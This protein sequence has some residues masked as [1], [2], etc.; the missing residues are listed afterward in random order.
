M[1]P[2]S[3]LICVFICVCLFVC[4]CESVH[5]RARVRR[6]RL[7]ADDGSDFVDS[8]FRLKT[9][10]SLVEKISQLFVQASV[11]LCVVFF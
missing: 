2:I 6:L 9:R 4:F 1:K 3:G 11:F 10:G 5:L 7:S 8:T